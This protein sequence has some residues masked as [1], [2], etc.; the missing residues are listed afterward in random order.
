MEKTILAKVNNEIDVLMRIS[1]I[2]RRKGFSM[3]S[4]QMNETTENSANLK[5]MLSY[6]NKCV[7]QL[8]NQIKKY[9]DVYELSIE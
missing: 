7:E 3:K 4:L 1:G 5:I 2:I 8:A 6:Q 9:S